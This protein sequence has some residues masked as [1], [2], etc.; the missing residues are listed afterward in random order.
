LGLQ[1]REKIKTMTALADRI[2][3]DLTEARRRRDELALRAL[4]MLKS[5]LI[6][7][8]KEAGGI[9]DQA[10]QVVLRREVK[11]RLEAAEAFASGGREDSARQEKAAADLL[12]G[13]LPAQL[14]EEE[15]EHEIQAVIVEVGAEGPRDLGRVIKAAVARVAG[16]A[17]PGR[18]AAVA[19]R[20]VT[21]G[22]SAG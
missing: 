8:S 12:Q 17:D 21:Q 1:V 10:A 22:T 5:E 9:N 15:L 3:I 13:Y 7:A 11:R 18:V 19:R 2:D 16:R 6:N 20:L 4:V 14:S